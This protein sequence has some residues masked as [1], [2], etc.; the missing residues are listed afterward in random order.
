M[1]FLSNRQSEFLPR[2]RQRKA[3]RERRAENRGQHHPDRNDISILAFLT[4][5]YC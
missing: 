3:A 5:A 1:V 2:A 4:E